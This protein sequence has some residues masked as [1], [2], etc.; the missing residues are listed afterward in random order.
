M[1]VRT[2]GAALYCSTTGRA[3]GPVFNSREEADAFLVWWWANFMT[4][5]RLVHPDLLD[6]R[7]HNFL[8][9]EGYAE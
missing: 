9:E 4:D 3:F 1:S 6:Q 8:K 7:Q 2:T 5:P